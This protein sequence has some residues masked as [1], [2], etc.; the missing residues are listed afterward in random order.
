MLR[1]SA[2][3]VTGLDSCGELTSPVLSAV[4]K[5]VSRVTI[6]EITTQQGTEVH[7][8]ELDDIRLRFNGQ[9]DVLGYSIDIDFLRVDAG[10]LSLVAGVPLVRAAD[11]SYG[12]GL[13]PFGEGPFGGVHDT[14]IVG[15][16]GEGPFGETPFGIGTALDGD[17]I[18]G[19]DQQTRLPAQSFGLEVWTTLAP[20]DCESGTYGYT[21]FPFLKGGRLSG[22]E[23]RNGLVSFNLRDARTRKHPRW[24]TGPYDIAGPHQRL[25]PPIRRGV[26][27]RTQKLDYLP[28]TQTDGITS[29]VDVIDGGSSLIT[30]GDTI[31]GEFTETSDWIINGGGA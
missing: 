15:G 9:T 30:S 17:T 29:F 23:F 12:F 22:F 28:P 2:V 27:W 20:A 10:M 14:E 7:K 31:D 16:F 11:G 3:R 1:S 18:R 4:S 8:D 5:S 21:V 13:G 24:N 25:N 6:N 19:F 26:A